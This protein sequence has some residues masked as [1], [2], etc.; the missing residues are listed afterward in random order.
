[1]KKH[2]FFW[3]F[4]SITFAAHGTAWIRV[5]QLGYLPNDTK[6]AVYLSTNAEN[7]PKAELYSALTAQKVDCTI[8]AE[9]CGEFYQFKSTFRLHFSEFSQTG[10]YYMVVDGVKSPVF[11]IAADVYNG[12]ADFLLNYMRQ[13][14]CGDNPSLNQICHQHDGFEVRGVPDTLPNRKVDVRGGW[15]DASDYLQYTTTSANAIYQML[16]AYKNN[17]QAFADNYDGTGRKGSNGI[18][19]ILD[20]A[21]WGLE[22]LSRMNPEKEIYYNQIADDRDHASFRLPSEDSVDYGWGAGTGRPVYVV[23]NEPQGLMKYKNR[24]N[25]K[26]STVGKFAS[27]FSLGSQLLQPY[28]PEFAK[29]LAD[30]AIEAFSYGLRYPGVSQT[31]P[32]RSPYFYEEDNWTDDMELAAITLFEQTKNNDYLN[33]AVAFGRMEPFTPWM[34]SDTAR[35]YQWY[36]FVNL[37]HF[38]ILRHASKKTQE[39]FTMNVR[40]A[41]ERVQSK[42]DKNP[43][44][45]GVPFIWC[46]NNLVTAMATHCHLYRTIT[47]DNQ[48]VEM[49]TAL[50][51]WLFGCNPWGT[52]MIVGLPEYAD[53]PHDPHSALW[54]NHRIPVL[55]GLVDGPVYGAIYNG[56]I[57]VRLSEP[58]EYADFQSN[59]AVYHDDWGDYS[60]NEPTMDGTASLTY[61]LSSL[62]QPSTDKN[63]Y[64]H[65]GI[66]KTNPE[67]KRISL[68]FSGHEY[69]DGYSAISKTLNKH[70]IKA[71]FFFT[72]DFYRNKQNK[73]LIKELVSN[74]HYIGAHSDKHLLYA[75]WEKQDSTLI[76][77]ETFITDIRANYAEIQ[78]FQPNIAQVNLFLPAF[79]FY[80]DTIASWAKSLGLQVVNYTP[81]TRTNGDYTIP[82]MKN[83]YSSEYLR[84]SVL[85]EEEK[86]GLNGNIMLIHIGTDTRRIDKFYDHLDELIVALQNK[87]YQFVG[88]P[89]AIK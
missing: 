25:G 2:L 65:G 1:M 58:D 60:S 47:G 36:P 41:I 75:A 50:R 69:A 55:G 33:R 20:E 62:A 14:R 42:A 83:Y 28:F 51:D 45:M 31:A 68:V 46:S 3:F 22:W 56:L 4:L 17:P 48:F 52:A 30:K 12:T 40:N 7:N 13:Q 10:N 8:N 39:E 26:A 86:N 89:E 88:L 82:E 37:G 73:Q 64:S 49:E 38:D 16:F 23:S 19:D 18:P 15:H 57:G 35:H 32:G 43:F 70:H 34:G 44:R 66:I 63:I 53:Y 71:A 6:T 79:E 24:S 21:K 61:Y 80:N 85:N 11:R 29:Q 74:Q 84:Q 54:V 78:K 27:S 77:R 81:G 76:S 9:S 72:G 59:W 87:G 5:N 67:L